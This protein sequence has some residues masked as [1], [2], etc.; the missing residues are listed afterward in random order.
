MSKF[1]DL[2]I[3]MTEDIGENPTT[4]EIDQWFNEYCHQHIFPPDI[5]DEDIKCDHFTQ[6]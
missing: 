6:D 1:S 5:E 3:Q 4:E 2:H